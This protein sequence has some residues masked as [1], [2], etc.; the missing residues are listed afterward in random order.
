MP[1]NIVYIV[2][3][4]SPNE[5]VNAT[6]TPN[7][8]AKL[9][10]K[11]IRFSAAYANTPLCGPF[12][13]TTLLGKYAHETGIGDNN[14]WPK[15]QPFEVDTVATRLQAAG[16]KTGL[17]GKY[18]NGYGQAPGDYI[19]PGWDRWFA[20]HGDYDQPSYEMV[21]QGT[22]KTFA[23][24]DIIPG[25]NFINEAQQ[26]IGDLLAV[27]EEP[28][29]CYLA[30]HSPHGPYDETASSIAD[31]SHFADGATYDSPAVQEDTA[32]ELADKPP[33]I[34][35]NAP[36][37]Q[38]E[39]DVAQKHQE[40]KREELRVVDDLLGRFMNWAFDQGLHDNTTYIFVSDN[41]YFRGEYGGMDNKNEAYE[42]A[43]RVPFIIRHPGATQNT[44]SGALVG[45]IDLYPTFLDIAGITPPAEASGRSLLPLLNGQVP[46]D[47]RKLL[48]LESPDAFWYALRDHTAAEPRKYINNG[49]P[50]GFHELYYL[51]P[52][53]YET[54]SKWNNLSSTAQTNM[55]NKLAA[56]K[57]CAGASCRTAEIP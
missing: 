15:F 3:D 39:R 18:L 52:D 57:A 5:M 9:S 7:V 8:T 27:Q 14:T 24:S 21:D 35:A 32:S 11:G 20:H 28:F 37:T 34:A 42:A 25:E 26:W 45:G 33:R 55:K 44:T 23:K 16:Y 30:F 48:L 6:N 1:N 51:T 19:P 41:G 46:A 22:L 54:D 43:A 36:L 10:Q 38:A 49:G 4:D 12:R 56:L 53:P 50:S 29:F 31:R 17:F 47:W 2:I 40:G 13:S